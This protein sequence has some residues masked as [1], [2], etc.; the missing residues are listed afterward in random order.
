[1]RCHWHAN[2]EH[3]F[4]KC[5]AVFGNFNGV[6]INANNTHIV[7]LPNAHF[8]ALNAKIKGSLTAHGWQNGIYLVV[9]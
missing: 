4:A 2:F 1:M 7:L 8:V 6:D 3:E 5:F 9:F